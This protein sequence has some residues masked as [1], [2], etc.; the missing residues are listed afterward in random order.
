M[1]E[2][3]KRVPFRVG[4]P[5]ISTFWSFLAFFGFLLQVIPNRVLDSDTALWD[6][7]RLK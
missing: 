2:A 7:Y 6:V 3:L 5:F 4:H 1:R